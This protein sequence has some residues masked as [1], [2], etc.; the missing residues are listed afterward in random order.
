MLTYFVSTAYALR[1]GFKLENR[2]ERAKFYTLGPQFLP[3]T[4]DGTVKA[5]P[6]LDRFGAVFVAQKGVQQR[7]ILGF[8]I[9]LV[10]LR[11]STIS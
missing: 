2:D 1:C 6:I 7:T 8:T 9:P 3:I 11:V 10:A 5:K 4:M